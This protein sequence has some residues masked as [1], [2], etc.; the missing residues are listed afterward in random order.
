MNRTQLEHIIRAASAIAN[1]D[2][3]VVIGSQAIHA[4]AIELPLSAY[5]SKEADVYP[6]N[7]PDR[8]ALIEGSLGRGSPFNVTFGYY[9]DGVAPETATLAPG[10]Q[11]RTIRLSNAN[12]GGATGVCLGIADIVVS[13]FAAGR[14]KDLSYNQALL[15]HG[16][17][18]KKDLTQLTRKLSLGQAEKVEILQRIETAFAY[19]QG[20]A[21]E[22]KYLNADAEYTIQARP[23]RE[24][25]VL[26]KIK[27]GEA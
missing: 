24:A 25:V 16:C 5:L 6:L 10:W 9:A 23:E 11:A 20:P 13:K 1:D 7:H 3:I 12:T 17:V 2:E 14:D 26:D 8:S 4:H 19:A 22:D 15:R 21:H 18:T 27:K